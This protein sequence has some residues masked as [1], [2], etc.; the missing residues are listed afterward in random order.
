MSSESVGADV[1]AN[2][3]PDR[4]ETKTATTDTNPLLATLFVVPMLIAQ[5]DRGTITGT[6]SDQGGA[7][8]PGASILL[9]NTATGSSYNT[10]TTE[11]GNYTVPSL[12]VGN[13]V[14]T[15]EYQSVLQFESADTTQR[16]RPFGEVTVLRPRRGRAS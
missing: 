10:V 12:P 8:I 1:G 2:E 9:Q 11:T 15:C 4:V 14:L 16:R 5:S 3:F 13:Y 6:V 7:T